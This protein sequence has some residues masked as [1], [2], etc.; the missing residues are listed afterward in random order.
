ME[1]MNLD[2]LIQALN[3]IRGRAME[4][5]VRVI[6]DV[7]CGEYEIQFVG[8]TYDSANKEVRLY[9]SEWALD[10]ASLES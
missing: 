10:R 3:E 4:Y 6:C 1:H 5:G 8:M 9:D 7:N 2:E